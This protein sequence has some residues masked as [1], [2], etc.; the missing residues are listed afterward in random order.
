MK[1]ALSL[2]LGGVLLLGTLSACAAGD[3][4][5]A[6]TPSEPEIVRPHTQFD[7]YVSNTVISTGNNTIVKE[8][9]EITYRAYFLPEEY[10]QFSYCFYF[11]NTVDSTWN[12]GQKS[13]A[14]MPGGSYEI[15]SASISDG[16]TAADPAQPVS[17][18]TAVTFG[19]Q[20]AKSVSPDETFWSDPV[21][22]SLEEGHYLV[23]EWTLTGTTIPA[24]AMSNM[25]NCFYSDGGG[26]IYCG[27][28]PLPVL[29]GC[30]RA[31]KGKVAF[32]GDSI[33][34]G[35]QTSDFA[36]RFWVSE[37]EKEIGDD[38][39]VWNLGLGHA[40]ASDAA[41]NGD[42]LARAKA[43]ETVVVAFGT[44]DIHTGSYGGDGPD[45]AAEVEAS[46]RTIVTELRNAGCEVIL[47]NAPPFG[48]T[49]GRENER[50]A[51]NEMLPQTAEETGCTLFDFSSLLS[52]PQDT[53][54]PLYGG[55]PNDEGCRLVAERFLRLHGDLFPSEPTD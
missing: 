9:K 15:L 44:N 10:G 37:I 17:G 18:T 43:Y 16:G 25:T 32:I 41:K 49:D 45:T 23:W 11:S 36:Y 31:V 14:G 26:F 48:Y 53:A 38:Y 6:S 27:E 1:K 3:T 2:L 55:H 21:D 39:A 51:L 28:T 5:S 29:I 46:I 7:D 19:G 42:W 8:A 4:P 34:Q 40:R 50:T 30:D 35:C 52:D 54:M 12:K 13:Y 47:F 20:T 33:T 22:F 24:I